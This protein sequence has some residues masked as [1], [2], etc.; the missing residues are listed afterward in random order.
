MA[1]LECFDIHDSDDDI[2]HG[3]DD[4]TNDDTDDDANDDADDDMILMIVGAGTCILS[5]L[6]DQGACQGTNR[7][8]RRDTNA[9]LRQSKVPIEIFNSR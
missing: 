4:D 8:P 9:I 5:R 7:H 6:K 2:D 3:T 1:L